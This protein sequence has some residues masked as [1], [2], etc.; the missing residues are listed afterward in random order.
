MD[1][2]WPA[3]GVFFGFCCCSAEGNQDPR[4]RNRSCRRVPL[5]RRA[6]ELLQVRED[7]AM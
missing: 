4:A 2:A 7:R 1:K 3:V 5:M 6:V